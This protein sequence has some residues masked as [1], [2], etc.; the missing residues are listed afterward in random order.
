MAYL[1]SDIPPEIIRVEI[2]RHFDVPTALAFSLVSRTFSETF[3]KITK[4]H[5][6]Q[7]LKRGSRS[8][9]TVADLRSLSKLSKILVEAIDLEYLDL[10]RYFVI[11][12]RFKFLSE[13]RDISFISQRILEAGRPDLCDWFLCL[14]LEYNLVPHREVIFALAA[15][16][17]KDLVLKYFSMWRANGED[18]VS[19][20]IEGAVS[21]LDF[22]WFLWVFDMV[23]RKNSA[24]KIEHFIQPAVE[25]SID[26]GICLFLNSFLMF[27]YFSISLL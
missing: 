1:W 15:S 6:F 5:K 11:E 21:T 3:D 2:P 13:S 22:E 4:P 23:K 7:P 27:E 16:R 9:Q 26:R 8:A 17:S 20:A 10:F 14:D 25:A 18:M 12:F 19:Q 24:L